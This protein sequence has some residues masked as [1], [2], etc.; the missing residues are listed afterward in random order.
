M[1]DLLDQ[2]LAA[3]G[4]FALLH[5]VEADRSVVDVL[6]GDVTTPELL[7][8]IELPEGPVSTPRHDVLAVVP[9]R[10]IGERGYVHRDDGAPLL[11][12]T[13]TDQAVLPLDDVLR[14]L[15][16]VPLDLRRGRF[17]TDDRGYAEIVRRVLADE[18]GEGEGANFVIRR[19]YVADVVDYSP[20]SALSLFRRLL[21]DET[22][23]Y[24]TFLVHTGERTFVGATPERHISVTGGTAVMNPISGTYRY[25]PT[26]PGLAGVLDFLADT[27]ESDELYMVL[28][29][30][31]KMMGRICADGG[32]VDGPYLREMARLAHTEY[33]IVGHTDRDPREVLRETM[34]A[35]T[36]TGSPL[37]SACRV[38][39]RYEPHGR[40]YYSGVVAL[41][42]RE[43]DGSRSLDSSILIRTAAIDAGGTVRVDVGATLV[44][45]SDPLAEVAETSAKAA[46]LLAALGSD[47]SPRTGGREGFAD[48]PEVRA[49]LRARNADIAR[50]WLADSG[51]R[52]LTDPALMG[53]R[54]LVVDAEDT[55]TAML[56]HQARALGLEVEVRRFDE[57]H[58]VR[59]ADLVLMGPGPGDPRDASHPKIAHLRST[60][61]VL[62][63]E[64]LPFLAVC[65]SHQV[66][67][68]RLG[69]PLVRRGTPNQ[70]VQLPV[71]LFG[72]TRL[73]GFYNTFAASSDRDVLHH[74]EFG[75][76]E[77]SRDPVTHQVH[78]LRGD[79]FASIQFH[80]ESVLTQDGP[81]VIGA[82]L[83]G[84]AR[85]A[86]E[87]A[88]V[89]PW[90]RAGLWPQPPV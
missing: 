22:G 75:Q 81:A 82:L 42:G 51:S 31:L 90:H 30:E 67:S 21:L 15:P 29:E 45:H 4:P 37:E 68:E 9:F 74:P 83:T 33:F 40:G 13:V 8:D 60:M 16:D 86:A 26:G 72:E 85:R 44:R 57:P 6:V 50:F 36:V 11:A 24:W 7:A 47:P 46:G 17:D 61:D 35:P 62:L 73:V 76:V 52:D 66:L 48:H 32:R 27:K 71:D 14:R 25:P 58:D 78:A 23:A 43:P 87:R 20:R 5:R 89:L 84:L 34:F 19:G 53:L 88:G 2:V 38:I 79:H 28:D 69:L 70:G 56:A 80:A 3:S 18:I 59:A 12:L 1:K 55:F 64:R 49:A 77:V 65:L 63:A 39:S 41:I 10:Q 54:L